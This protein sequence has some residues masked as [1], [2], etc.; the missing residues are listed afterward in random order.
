MASEVALIF[1]S[2]AVGLRGRSSMHRVPVEE[3]LLRGHH[4]RTR[5][6]VGVGWGGCSTQDASEAWGQTP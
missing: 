6:G 2:W 4:P 1:F 5:S 3:G